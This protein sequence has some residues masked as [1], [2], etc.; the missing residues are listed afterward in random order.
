MISP[1]LDLG[2]ALPYTLPAGGVFDPYSS[3][4]WDIVFT[5]D[6][7]Y[8]R[9][10]PFRGELP[11]YGNIYGLIPLNRDP[12]QSSYVTTVGGVP[13]TTPLPGSDVVLL[14]MGQSGVSSFQAPGPVGGLSATP[15][16]PPAGTFYAFGNVAPSPANEFGSPLPPN[17]TYYANDTYTP[18]LPG[19]PPVPAQPAGSV[20]N[21]G[22]YAIPLNT[23]SLLQSL[24]PSIATGGTG[25]ATFDPMNAAVAAPTINF[26]PGVLPGVYLPAG[27]TSTQTPPNNYSWKIPP[28]TAL[29]NNATYYWVCLRR[30]ANPFAP[31]SQT[32]PM[33][34]VDAMRVPYVDGSGTTTATDAAGNPYIKG[35][36]NTV[37]SVQR[38]QPYRGGH[39]VPAPPPAVGSLAPPPPAM[40][41]D[42]RYG[43][44]EQVVSPTSNSLYALTQGI[45]YSNTGAAPP[46]IYGATQPIYHTLGWANEQESGSGNPLAEPWDYLP[47]H[48]RD[49]TSVAELLLVPGSPPGLFTK[50]FAEFAPSYA[51][52]AS[53]FSL[54]TPL[55]TTLAPPALT[56][57]AN[58]QATTFGS[59][60]LFNAAFVSTP[61]TTPLI[62]P[63]PY[64][65]GVTPTAAV[66]LPTGL[67]PPVPGA[68]TGLT[69]EPYATGSTTLLTPSGIAGGKYT[70]PVQPHSFPYLNDKFFY[71]AYG[72]NNTLDP[73][74][75]TAL[76]GGYA[77]DGWFKM[78]EFFEVPSQMIGA[79]GTVAQGTNFDW[80]RQ[81]MKPGQ[82]NLNM[83]IDEEVF[84]S[85]VGQQAYLDP[86]TGWHAAHQQNGQN[87]KADGVTPQWPSDQFSQQLLNFN[88]IANPYVP[89]GPM[90]FL[91]LPPG[92]YALGINGTAANNFPLSAGSPPV[93]LVVTSTLSNGAPGTAYPL[94]NNQYGSTGVLTA[95]PITN[96]FLG[97]STDP[98][99]GIPPQYRNQLKAAWIQFLWLRHGGSGYMFG[100]GSGAVGSNVSINGANGLAGFTSPGPPPVPAPGIPAEMPFHSLSYPDINYT[101]M[102]PAA[103]P[104]TAFTTPVA[105]PVAGTAAS[106]LYNSNPG[107]Y[108]TAGLW[109]TISS[110]PGVRNYFLYVPYPPSAVLTTAAPNPASGSIPGTP[111]P[112]PA[113]GAAVAPGTYWPVYPPPIP[114]RRLFQPPDA[115]NPNP[116]TLPTTTAASASNASE[117]GD[118]SLNY[119][120]VIP[121]PATPNAPFPPAPGAL[122]PVTFTNGA[123]SFAGVL[124]NS[125]VNLFWPGAN[126]ATIYDPTGVMAPTPVPGGHNPY[127]GAGST[128]AGTDMRQHPYWRTEQLQRVMNLTTSRT[129][130]Y[131]VWITIG[132]FEVKRQGDLGMLAVGGDPRLAFDILGPEIG[133]AN[134]KNT[135]YRGFYLVDRLQLTGFNPASVSAFRSAVVYRQR[136]Q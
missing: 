97:S 29:A 104:P 94:T 23:P 3:A 101:V 56:P 40:Q 115:Y 37:F 34:V 49:F 61:A 16:P 30:P 87:F 24:N 20:V 32:N 43:Y 93:P 85:L 99:I 89:N 135:R 79:I 73:G 80:L 58:T 1:A 103:L 38:Y 39:A 83:I 19:P 48:D 8:S 4:P 71:S 106:I 121:V 25:V 46:L 42:P 76:V 130:Q 68:N 12:F 72:A 11:I 108:T 109:N 129:H 54:V 69:G 133:A 15:T 91:Q 52:I 77:A 110:D 41:V 7:P 55:Q 60:K 134:G 28:V 36:F 90:L 84:F 51:S 131:A 92:N 119:L 31:V 81:D 123:A 22:T 6:D 65:P 78:F 47:F 98:T 59:A 105:N 9:P 70:T 111:Y 82:L 116:T 95:D 26:Y 132:F 14:P 27:N 118:P 107:T 117:T 96:F 21:N 53:V 64:V 122:P 86:M 62:A 5:A 127:L 74:G 50:Q 114:A 136:I 120:T 2:G 113:G 128:A 57:P 63:A 124:S 13:T 125:V 18:A 33:L 100:W 45:Y 44:S 112:A 66:S 88:Q 75:T 10:D 17:A 102:R 35:T 67:T 126:A